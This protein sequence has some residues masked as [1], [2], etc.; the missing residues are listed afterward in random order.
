MRLQA[1]GTPDPLH[2]A[3]R[4]A[5]VE[6]HTPRTPVRGIVRLALQRAG[7]DRFDALIVDCVRRTGARF[8]AQPLEPL[9]EKA[10][11]PLA[12]RHGMHAQPLADAE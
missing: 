4:E 1:K 9:I 2:R 10:A 8:I 11:T 12:D 7:D 6:R 5:T 3:D